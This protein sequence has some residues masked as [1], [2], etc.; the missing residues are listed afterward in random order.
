[1]EHYGH[2]MLNFVNSLQKSPIVVVYF[3]RTEKPMVVEQ[4]SVLNLPS[5]QYYINSGPKD[6]WS[7]IYRIS[8][9]QAFMGKEHSEIKGGAFFDMANIGTHLTVAI[10]QHK[11]NILLSA[12]M[13]SY[14]ES[15][16]FAFQVEHSPNYNII[17][18][19]TFNEHES[20]LP[21]KYIQTGT[22]KLA[23]KDDLEWIEVLRKIHTIYHGCPNQQCGGNVYIVVNGRRCK[24]HVGKR[25]GKYIK[26]NGKK[27]YIQN[28]GIGI[29]E[30][31]LRFVYDNIIKIVIDHYS[32][33]L[34]YV[35]AKLFYDE[36]N[37]REFVICYDLIE[38]GHRRLFY[39]DIQKT[40]EAYKAHE[41][42]LPII[43]SFRALSKVHI[44]T[45]AL[46][47]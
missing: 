38:V 8:D 26:N 35:E 14:E 22:L 7:Y 45:I 20:L 43:E 30:N 6:L 40:I 25:G 16:D 19:T 4:L 11:S 47:S 10:K 18:N 31:I 28:G 9:V 27:K 46:L 37:G 1:M 29:N 23:F 44:D 42:N 3:N 34:S 33:D 5:G 2:Q 12:H 24:V 17:F 36:I 15:D 39:L 21:N 13:T 41:A 32:G